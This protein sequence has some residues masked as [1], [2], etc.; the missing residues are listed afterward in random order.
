MGTT[1]AS[2][3]WKSWKPTSA[4][5]MKIM[6]LSD[7]CAIFTA[8]GSIIWLNISRI[9]GIRTLNDQT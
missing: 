6:K 7:A 9:P 3:T 2:K 1:H 4:T 8:T 5:P